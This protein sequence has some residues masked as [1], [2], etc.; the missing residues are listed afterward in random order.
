MKRK[1]T[2]LLD[3]VIAHTGQPI[4]DEFGAEMN[5]KGILSNILAMS[6]AG[7]DRA[8]MA[9]SLATRLYQ[10]TDEEII[11][12]D[13]EYRLCKDMIKEARLINLARNACLSILDN[14]EEIDDTTKT[15]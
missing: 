10:S 9:V 15:E 14:A 12:D 3:P 11:L 7:T 1:L 5:A 6:D 4:V 13:F 2:K 8:A